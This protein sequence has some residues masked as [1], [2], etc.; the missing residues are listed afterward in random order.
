MAT[1]STAN[2]STPSGPQ[3]AVAAIIFPSVALDNPRLIQA[4]AMDTDLTESQVR[5]GRA[6]SA[7]HGQEITPSDREPGLTYL[8]CFDGAPDGHLPNVEAVLNARDMAFDLIASV[9][10]AGSSR[11]CSRP[12]FDGRSPASIARFADDRA[13]PPAVWQSLE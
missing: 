12:G 3:C 5:T 6:T 7:D 2:E 4:I 11:T 9:P 1:L 8:T 10:N 13:A